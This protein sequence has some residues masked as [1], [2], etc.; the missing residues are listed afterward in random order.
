MKESMFNAFNIGKKYAER[1][2]GYLRRNYLV[3][4]KGLDDGDLFLEGKFVIDELKTE[5][6]YEQGKSSFVLVDVLSSVSEV[7]EVFGKYY[8]VKPSAV[9]KLIKE[10]ENER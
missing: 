1:L 2:N 6:R 7:E 8:F 10:N 5:I 3:F 9:F 4:G